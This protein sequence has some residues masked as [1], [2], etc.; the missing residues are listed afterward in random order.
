[1]SKRIIFDAKFF[2]NEVKRVK[3]FWLHPKHNRLRIEAHKDTQKAE[4]YS[5]NKNTGLETAIRIPV[6]VTEDVTIYIKSS[7]NFFDIVELMHL[8]NVYDE[9]SLILVIEE[10]PCFKKRFNIRVFLPS[11]D[12]VGSFDPIP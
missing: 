10:N 12:I 3:K 5:I 9:D 1:M 8:I 6:T 7:G 4:F 2:L 11:K